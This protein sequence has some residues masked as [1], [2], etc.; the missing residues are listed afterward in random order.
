MLFKV[1]KLDTRFLYFECYVEILINFIYFYQVA[2]HADALQGVLS[3][4]LKVLLHALGSNQSTMVLQNMFATQRSL[5]YKVSGF[6]IAFV[7]QGSHR[8]E[9]SENPV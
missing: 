4:V 5:V 2:C 6:I 9:K 8:W 7:N 1:L 3:T